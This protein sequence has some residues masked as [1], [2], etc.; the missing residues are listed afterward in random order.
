ML[1]LELFVFELELV[2]VVVAVLVDHH[3]CKQ[4]KTKKLILLGC[5]L[6]V[7]HALLYIF[8]K[9]LI[10]LN[11]RQDKLSAFYIFSI[12]YKVYQLS[13]FETTNIQLYGHN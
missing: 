4:N 10:R 8:A 13:K 2:V 12:L 11:P 5:L 7:L 9:N 1:I 6:N 3:S